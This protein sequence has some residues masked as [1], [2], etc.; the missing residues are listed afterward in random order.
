[1]L[2]SSRWLRATSASITSALPWNCSHSKKFKTINLASFRGTMINR[3]LHDIERCACLEHSSNISIALETI[4]I[5]ANIFHYISGVQYVRYQKLL[6]RLQYAYFTSF[7]V[8]F[9]WILKK[10]HASTI[11]ES[12]LLEHE[13]VS[14]RRIHPRML[15][16]K[17]FKAKSMIS[18]IL[19]TN[20][21]Q[22]ETTRPDGW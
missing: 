2:M 6:S 7:V 22:Y 1:M 13:Y 16:N 9:T 10:Y 12:V 11:D 5:A 3:E 21:L 14:F 15:P 20:G 4:L 17:I 19:E 18:I 8:L